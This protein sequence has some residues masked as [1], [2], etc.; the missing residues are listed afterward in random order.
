[1]AQLTIQEKYSNRDNSG[2]RSR[3]FRVKTQKVPLSESFDALGALGVWNASALDNEAVSAAQLAE[4]TVVSASGAAQ[5]RMRSTH[6]ALCRAQ[7][8]SS[9]R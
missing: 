7:L 9:C 3:V 1:V 6:R 8:V 2:I 4:W 5:H